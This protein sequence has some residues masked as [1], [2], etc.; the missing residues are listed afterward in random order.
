MAGFSKLLPTELD[1]YCNKMHEIAG[2]ERY[3]FLEKQGKR[4]YDSEIG[5]AP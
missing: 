5:I 1:D 4:Q 3:G 2:F